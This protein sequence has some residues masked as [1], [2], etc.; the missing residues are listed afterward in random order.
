MLGLGQS[1]DTHVCL[2]NS[3]EDGIVTTPPVAD[4]SDIT[5]TPKRC[6]FEDDCDSLHA[7]GTPLMGISLSF[8]CVDYSFGRDAREA[9]SIFM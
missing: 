7:S 8:M 9:L 1:V 2:V 3:A 4:A 6:L 5:V